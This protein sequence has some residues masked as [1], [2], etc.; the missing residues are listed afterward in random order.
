[1][2][3]GVH[4]FK[5]D[6][7]LPNTSGLAAFWKVFNSRN[8][9]PGLLF[10]AYVKLP[11][12]R[13]RYLSQ[14]QIYGLLSKLSNIEKVDEAAMLRY[15]TV[16]DDMKTGRVPIPRVH[17]NVAIS[18]VAKCYR[19]LTDHDL[20]SGLFLW[21]EMEKVAGMPADATTFNI[22]FHLAANSDM[23]HLPL[24]ILKEMKRRRVSLDRFSYVNLI[25]YYGGQGNGSGIRATYRE[26]VSS[27]EVVDIVVLNAIMTALIEAG[28]PQAAE[29][30]L[31]HLTR[32]NLRVRQTQTPGKSNARLHKDMKELRWILG[33]QGFDTGVGMHQSPPAPNIISFAIFIDYHAS[34][35]ADMA[36]VLSILHNLSECGI[37]AET[38]IF[39]SLFKGFSLHGRVNYSPWTLQKLN[40]VFEAFVDGGY[41]IN[42]DATLWCLR[43]YTILAGKEKAEGMWQAVRDRWTRQGAEASEM[44]EVA[45]RLSKMKTR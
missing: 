18:F 25:T 15:L 41:R 39:Q 6:G 23:A 40:A 4:S 32:P 1:M 45:H 10:E 21:R 42:R 28:E 9:D 17:W 38:T 37:S 24:M 7:A 11:N 14:E 44:V 26:L 19:R 8:I 30:I 43:A 3:Q 20:Q 34:E 29:N 27:G 36:K 33:Q 31:A 35:T 12:P 2:T 16:I 22:L 13:L 5:S